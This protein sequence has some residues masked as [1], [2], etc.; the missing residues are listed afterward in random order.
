LGLIFLCGLPGSGKTTVGNTIAQLTG[1]QFIDLDDFVEGIV[2]KPI[3]RIFM[4]EGE[5]AFREYEEE[6]LIRACEFDDAVIA[7]GAGALES[8]ANLLMSLASGI[9]VYLRLEPM[10]IAQRYL[11]WTTRPLMAGVSTHT[12]IADRLAALLVRRESNY[13]HAE[14][15]MNVLPQDNPEQ[16][17]ER[18]LSE[19]KLR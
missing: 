19:L 4:E 8:Q 13:L 7:L 2:G 10:V 5:A 1:R 6:A 17:A 9:L 11:D 3:A 18:I 15:V 16:T 12:Q 14:I